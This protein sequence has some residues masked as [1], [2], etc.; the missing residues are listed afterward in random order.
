[1]KLQY[2]LPCVAF[3]L[4]GIPSASGY[5]RTTRGYHDQTY[6]EAVVELKEAGCYNPSPVP[7]VHLGVSC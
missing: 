5:G 7:L 1:M 6:D 4:A 2:V 3:A